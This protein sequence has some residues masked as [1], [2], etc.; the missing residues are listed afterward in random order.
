M[1][2]PRAPARRRGFSLVELLLVVTVVGI[3]S[4]IAVPALSRAH[5]VAYEASTIGSLRAIH[6][7]QALFASSCGG[8]YYAHSPRP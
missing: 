8:G 2:N 1:T 6:T 4:A 3:L 7:A 5:G